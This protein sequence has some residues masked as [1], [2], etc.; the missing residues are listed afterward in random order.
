M[1]PRAPAN[2]VLVVALPP[3][4]RRVRSGTPAQA[5]QCCCCC[6]C[7][8]LHSVGSVVGAIVTPLVWRGRRPGFAHT[9]EEEDYGDLSAWADLPDFPGRRR[10]G[11]V[12][13]SAVAVFWLSSLA[14][15]LAALALTAAGA[16]DNPNQAAGLQVAIGLVL[17]ALGFPALQLI[18]AIVT[19]FVL[20]V[21]SRTDKG[22]QFGQLGKITLGVV[23]GTVLGL[24]VMAGVV[25]VARLA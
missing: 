12:W 4:R 11:S 15:V 18:A 16:L 13:S 10:A 3:E 8:C 7:C 25:V 21:S 23:I 20:G 5:G 2:P 14:L 6:C 1:S 19:A 17:L 9:Q 22:Y 24:A